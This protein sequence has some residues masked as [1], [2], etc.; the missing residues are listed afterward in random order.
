MAGEIEPFTLDIAESELDYLKHRL[1]LTRWPD[2]EVVDDWSQGA[3]LAKVRALCDYWL[4]SYD[5]RRCE[6][7][8]NQF[9]Q[10][11]T[12]IDGLGVHFLHARSP[13]QD[14]LPIVIAHGWP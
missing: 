4:N 9:G 1:A 3:P 14:A 12:Q 8:L 7:M 2:A 13:E 6:S 11:R 5:W 10:F